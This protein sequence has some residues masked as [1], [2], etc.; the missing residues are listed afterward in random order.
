MV[1]GIGIVG[2]LNGELDM[3]ARII[4]HGKADFQ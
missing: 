1:F 4:R 3:Q 2:N